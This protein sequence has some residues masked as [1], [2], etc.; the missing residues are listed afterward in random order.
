MS[1]EPTEKS[2]KRMQIYTEKYWEKTGTSPHPTEKS[3]TQSSTAL[4]KT[5]M[6]SVAHF[7]LATFIPT[8]RPNSNAA[9]NGSVPVT[10]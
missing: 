3:P 6:N 4:H 10:K 2:L 1:S 9:A 5:S 7:A 8:K